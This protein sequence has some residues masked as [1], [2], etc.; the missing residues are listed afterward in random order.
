MNH[1]ISGVRKSHVGAKRESQHRIGD[2]LRGRYGGLGR[3]VVEFHL[4]QGRVMDSLRSPGQACQRLFKGDY[5]RLLAHP[6]AT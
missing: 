1:D 3:L 2:P 6:A 5:I 4:V